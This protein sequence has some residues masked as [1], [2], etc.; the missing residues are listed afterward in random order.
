MP[1]PQAF[2]GKGWQNSLA[3]KFGITSIPATFLIKEDISKYINTS[4]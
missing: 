3:K 4:K 1:W 2:D